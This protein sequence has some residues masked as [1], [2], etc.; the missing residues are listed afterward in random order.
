MSPKVIPLDIGAGDLRIVRAILRRHV[1][2]RRVVA[3][4]SRARGGARKFSDLDIAVVSDR[5][6]DGRT[7]TRMSHAFT[8][9]DLPMRVDVSEWRRF[10][11]DFRRAV[12]GDCVTVQEGS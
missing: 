3:Y 12:A 6:V 1:P 5:P 4:G 10:S 9:S 2:G 7:M 11:D 8:D